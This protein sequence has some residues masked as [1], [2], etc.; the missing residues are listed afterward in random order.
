MARESKIEWTDLPF[1]PWVGCQHVSPGCD[2]C[3]AEADQDKRFHRVEWGPH[4]ERKRT[5]VGYW[6]GPLHWNA[7]AERFERLHAR[8]RRVFCAPLADV[9]DNQCRRHGAPISGS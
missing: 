3:C 6:R 7:D 9:F 8:R 4:G 5:T 2:N 1:N